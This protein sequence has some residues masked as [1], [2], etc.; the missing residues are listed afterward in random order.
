V[1]ASA[2][3]LFSILTAAAE[4]AAVAPKLA[5]TPSISPPASVFI[6][7]FIGVLLRPDEALQLRRKTPLKTPMNDLFYILFVPDKSNFR[8]SEALCVGE[9]SRHGLV[10]RQPVRSQVTLRLWDL[11]GNVREVL[12]QLGAA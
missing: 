6:V 11:R 1:M 10:F 12:V 5:A 2:R 3:A 4:Y 9:R 7:Q 8:Y